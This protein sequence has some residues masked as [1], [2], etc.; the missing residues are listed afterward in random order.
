[1]DNYVKDA[2]IGHGGMSTVY[3]G[4]D[5]HGRLVA[6]KELRPEFTSN[7]EFRAR[8]AREAQT[9]QTIANPNVVK[10]YD[11]VG[12]A[13]IMEY[14]DGTSLA[15]ELSRR[16]KL[17]EAEALGVLAQAAHGL[18]DIH[19]AGMIHRDIKP[20]NLLISSDG[21]VK[22]TDFGI[23]KA[24]SAV[25][26]TR[27]GMVMGTAQY[28]SPE[29]AQGNPLT[30]ASDVY[31]LGVVGFEMLSGRRPFAGDNTV[32]VAIA[33]INQAAPELPA[34]ISA[35]TRQLINICLRKDPQLR[36]RDGA[37]LE[38]AVR[39]VLAGRRPPDP[40]PRSAPA[41]TVLPPVRRPEPAPAPARKH[42]GWQGGLAVILLAGIIAL[43]TMITRLPTGNDV[44][45]TE[46]VTPTDTVVVETTVTVV[47]PAP[48]EEQ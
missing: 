20:G 4:H 28:V 46:T 1:M 15:D 14:V 8:L 13:I 25:P 2:V 17:P 45:V 38:F 41:T 29:Q 34:P 40:A 27:T 5:A 32:S 36:Y 42:L 6:I 21:T 22:I 7:E 10:T 48:E 37:A 30:P 11:Y 24:A 31:S 43:V 23:A 44:V 18:S 9:A 33:H 3:R 39:E 47:E 16:V 35:H 12:S 19:L 26:I